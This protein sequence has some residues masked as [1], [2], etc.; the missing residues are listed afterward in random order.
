MF[1]D[2]HVHIDRYPN[3]TDV[4]AGATAAQVVC[5]AVTET[6]RDFEMLSLRAGRRPDLRVALGAHP[7]R[8]GSLTS[9]E[10]KRFS[11]L[12]TRADYVGEVGLD[13]SR[14]GRAT[15][16]AQRRVF[17]HVLAT[18][19]IDDRVLTVHSRGAEA[20]TIAA[21]EQAGVTAVLH[22][23]SGA[24]KH[25][26]AA[27]QAGFYFSINAPML[28]SQK[29]SKLLAAL[30]R[31]RV[32]TETDGPYAKTGAR[33]S[34]PADV[35]RIVADLAGAWS[36]TAEEARQLIWTNMTAIHARA[37]RPMSDRRSGDQLFD[38]AG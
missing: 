7:M 35:R 14:D 27:L 5:V 31:D 22:W 6:P 13:G 32:V 33:A 19:G 25:A 29:G 30:P 12:M 2:A 21:L 34:V 23:Y 3:P 16:R 38:R 4:L 36:C 1:V 37:K 10:L 17:E 18:P 11:V 26:E 24:L 15:I 28:R 8:A 9:E 20:E